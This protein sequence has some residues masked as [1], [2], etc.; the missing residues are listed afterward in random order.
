MYGTKFYN[1]WM[2]IKTRCFNSKDI[3]FSYYGGRGIKCLWNS[4]KEFR[5]DMYE[6]YLKHVAEFGEKQTTIDRI[7]N[8]GNYCKENCRWATLQEQQINRSTTHF[9]TFKGQTKHIAEWARILGING[10]TLHERIKRGWD[11]NH[12]LSKIF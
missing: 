2:H 9:L 12:V 1:T 6:S 10:Q 7:D 4:F 8:D 11:T 5:D 3:M